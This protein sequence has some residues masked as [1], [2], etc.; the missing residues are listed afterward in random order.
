MSRLPR[1]LSPALLALAAL[2]GSPLAARAADSVAL[3][4]AA[5]RSAS[6]D[7]VAQHLELGGTLFGYMDVDGDVERIAAVVRGMV[8]NIAAE[9]PQAVLFQQDYAKI[10]AD[11]GLTDVKA[12]G[13][14]SVA[15]E[16]GFRNRCFFYT[17][18]GRHGLLAALGGPATP[19]QNLDL[20]PDN[21]DLFCENE[22][23]LSAAYSAIREVVG[24]VAGQATANLLD[25]Q[26]KGTEQQAGFSALD[27]VQRLKGRV[28]CIVRFEDTAP[29]TLPTPKPIRIPAFSLVL[30]IDGI[31]PTF[32]GLLDNAPAFERTTEGDTTIYSLKGPLPVEG[33]AP[34]LAIDGDAL[35]LATSRGIYDTCFQKG[36]RLHTLPALTAALDSLG[37]TGNGLTYISPGCFARLH[38]L[39]ELNQDNPEF[40]R[41]LQFALGNLP[42]TGVPMVSV[43]TNL[44]DG[45]L[46]RSTWN[47]SLKQNIAAAT[48]YNPVTIGLLSAMAIPA[49]QKV[50]ANSQ[51]NTIKNNLRQLS[52]AA[53]QFYLEND[54]TTATYDDL[55]GPDRYIK[56]LTSV[57]GEDYRGIVFES[58]TPIQLTLPDGEVVEVP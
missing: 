54:A 38:Q 20:A 48:V 50:R 21:A 34:L 46:F 42:Q 24:Y 14:S 51:Q 22:V 53:Q 16:G 36:A 37:R 13:L 18:G 47:S 57:A 15:V 12:I 17:P 33:W 2:A 8:D 25:A 44:P 58:G 5:E 10:A 4:P 32:Q 41:S 30:R 31:A 39:A 45:I 29:I 56:E 1:W 43:R 3:V 28:T 55:V 7:A 19:F 23:D 52:A 27:L 6:F 40:A 9:V 49:F 26:L 11:L 35:Y